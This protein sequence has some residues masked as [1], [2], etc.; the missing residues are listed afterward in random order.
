MKLLSKII[1]FTGLVALVSSCQKE[2]ILCPQSCPPEQENTE[3]QR[4][5]NP[6][7]ASEHSAVPATE[8]SNIPAI[9]GD[10]NTGAEG[11]DIV[12]GGDDDRDGGGGDKKNKRPR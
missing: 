8:G 4:V 2:N 10:P 6:S 7:D 3:A 12:G 5:G 9:K 11:D 1:I